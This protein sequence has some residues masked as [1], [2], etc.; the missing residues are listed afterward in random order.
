M[1]SKPCIVPATGDLKCT[2]V[3]EAWSRPI[4]MRFA[5]AAIPA[6]LPLIAYMGMCG[7]LLVSSA[8]KGHFSPPLFAIKV[9]GW[10]AIFATC[11][12]LPIYLV[13]SLLSRELTWRQRM[14][15]FAILLIQPAIFMP[16]FLYGK[17]TGKTAELIGCR[18]ACHT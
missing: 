14:V 16:M 13:W 10:T 2:P 1:I 8:T 9:L 12:Q 7:W 6:S 18:R 3:P 4:R 17:Y 11:L 5:W 15:W